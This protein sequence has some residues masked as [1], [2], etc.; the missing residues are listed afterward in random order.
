MYVHFRDEI[1]PPRK[2]KEKI[3]PGQTRNNPSGKIKNPRKKFKIPGE[4]I[5]LA[6]MSTLAWADTAI[7]HFAMRR[8]FRFTEGRISISMCVPNQAAFSDNHV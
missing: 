1:I 8:N 6:K 4:F 3:I 5:C 7:V 2:T